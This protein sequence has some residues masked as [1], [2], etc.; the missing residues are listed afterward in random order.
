M[1]ALPPFRRP[2]P[3]THPRPSTPSP[4]YPLAALPPRRSTPSPLYPLAA[5]P[6]RQHSGANAAAP[7]QRRQ[8]SGAN[9]AAPTQ[10]RQLS[11]ANAAAPTQQLR[12]PRQRPRGT[13]LMPACPLRRGLLAGGNPF[14]RPTPNRSAAN[15]DGGGEAAE[16]ENRLA[17]LRSGTPHSRPDPSLRRAERRSCRRTCPIPKAAAPSPAPNRRRAAASGRPSRTHRVAGPS[18]PRPRRWRSGARSPAGPS[19]PGH[20]GSTSTGR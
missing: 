2:R 12:Q 8:L 1:L 13:H 3:S 11:G 20:P 4:L 16:S 18:S 10:R 17:G 19:S 7:T 5:L 14:R 9:S 15:P 6:P